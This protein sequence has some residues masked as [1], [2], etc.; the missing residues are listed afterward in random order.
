VAPTGG[1]S[2]VKTLALLLAALLLLVAG[3][4][5]GHGLW[6]QASSPASSLAPTTRPVPR[7]TPTTSPAPASGA[8]SDVTA[9][10]SKVD[11][12]LVDINTT[13]SFQGEQAAG[14]GMVLTSSGEVLTNNH[15]ID[16]ATSI[17]VTDV[18]NGQT[19]SA[20]V[21]GYDDT[22][23]LAV[24]QLHGAS[25]LQTVSIGNSSKVSVGQ[26]VVGIGNAGGTGGTPSSAGGSVTAL[27]QTI[28][29]SD[30]GGN[31]EQL[32]GLTESNADIQP[33][34]S[35]GPLVNDSG[36]VLGIDTA[37]SAG[38]QF[39]GNAGESY[40][41]PINSAISVAKQIEAGHGSAT[42]HIG[43]T[44]F[45]GVSVEP[46]NG[47]GGF[48]GGGFSGGGFGGGGSQATGVVVAGVVTGDPAD[49]AGISTG[50][51][52]T[53]FAGSAVDTPSALTAALVS[54][55][56]GDKVQ[57]G[58]TDQS[59]QSHTATVQLASGPPA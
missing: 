42:I 48:S 20:T 30:G 14:T 46:T 47:S 51:T 19:Y 31:S 16:G 49:G 22:S 6:S 44:G 52:I 23:D 9:I 13:L 24:L 15:V 33:G 54:H 38:F 53:S 35:G 10:A 28:T 55:H 58:W 25:G 34:D 5:I 41:I 12:G 43:L 37:A 8:P 2:P 45:L 27:N 39:S 32:S 29:A 26:S 11:P 3:V 36:R 40:S 18:G 17:S 57:I 7:V 59:G 56:P 4:A 21:V 50:D 1:G